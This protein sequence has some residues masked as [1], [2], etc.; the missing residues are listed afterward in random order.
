MT[1]LDTLGSPGSEAMAVSA[2]TGPVDPLVLDDLAHW[3]SAG[4]KG[5]RTQ[6]VVPGA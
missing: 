1:D 4:V 3:L 2:A 6:A 5:K